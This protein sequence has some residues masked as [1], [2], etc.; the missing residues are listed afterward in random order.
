MKHLLLIFLMTF[1]APKLCAEISDIQRSGSWYYLYDEKGHRYKTISVSA[2]GDLVGWSSTFFVA[3]NGSWYNLYDTEGK[4]YKTMSVSA[5]GDI[6]SVAGNCF[7]ARSGSWI[8]TYDS[9]GKRI[10]TRSR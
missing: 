2:V 1:L 4:R 6:I 7:T 3:R 5:V 8:Y 9:S 10:A